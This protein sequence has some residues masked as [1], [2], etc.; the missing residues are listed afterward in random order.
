MRLRG[1][2]GGRNQVK[3]KSRYYSSAKELCRFLDNSVKAL[4][5]Q[6]RDYSIGRMC[7]SM[8]LRLPGAF[9]LF[10]LFLSPALQAQSPALI[11]LE[12]VRFESLP[13]DWLKAEVE[14]QANRNPTKENSRFVSEI[15]ITLNLSFQKPNGLFVF[16]RCS[17][18]I[19][20]LE[21]NE[22][23]L[24]A[25]YFPGILMERDNLREPFAYLV[26]IEAEGMRQPFSRESASANI[27]N[28]PQ[29][30]TSLKSRA[31]AAAE[32][33]DGILLPEYLAPM[34]YQDLRNPPIYR[35]RQPV[36][37]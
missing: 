32:E 7:C 11:E 17:V 29:A 28:N 15:E 21:Q 22:T 31:E 1:A 13:D 2:G 26:E 33:N 24:V 6:I 5:A 35:R 18:E 20:A 3:G 14:V 9:L 36:Q 34:Q 25:F 27:V 37:P 12:Q 8:R 30:V 10:S 4:P 23:A 16:Y 19:V